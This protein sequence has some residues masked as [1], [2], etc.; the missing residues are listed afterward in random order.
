M[1][2]NSIENGIERKVRFPTVQLGLAASTVKLGWSFLKKRLLGREKRVEVGRA[3]KDRLAGG[4]E[5][6]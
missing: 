1:E 4:W 3:D 2:R 5:D 6:K